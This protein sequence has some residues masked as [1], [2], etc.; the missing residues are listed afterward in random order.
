MTN[1]ADR[2]RRDGSRLAASETTQRN[3]PIRVLSD[4][5]E[6]ATADSCLSHGEATAA[7]AISTSRPAAQE[8]KRFAAG[9]HSYQ[10][11]ARRCAPKTVLRITDCVSNACHA[12]LDA[13]Q[14]PAMEFLG[15]SAR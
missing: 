9:S 12:P 11:R 14:E 13:E 15:V 7:A 3:H 6:L 5:R 2:E 1:S 4:A 10:L 8:S